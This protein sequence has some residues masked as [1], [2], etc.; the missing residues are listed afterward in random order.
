MK[1]MVWK[2]WFQIS[3]HTSTPNLVAVMGFPNAHGPPKQQE[4]YIM[5][6][7]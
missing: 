1:T 6:S 7:L 5:Q 4:V 3:F 2:V